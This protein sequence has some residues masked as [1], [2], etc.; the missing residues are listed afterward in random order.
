[1]DLL[2]ARIQRLGFRVLRAKTPADAY[3]A[4]SNARLG[5][6][7]AVLPQDLPVADLR[8]AITRLRE[9]ASE[10]MLSML[11]TGPRPEHS[12]RAELRASGLD[13]AIF[14]PID[15]HSLRFQLNRA[16]AWRHSSKNR[17]TERAPVTWNVRLRAS[18]RAKEGRVYTLSPR[19]LFVSL[20]APWLRGTGVKLELELPDGGRLRCSGRVAMTNVKGNLMKTA[21]PVGMGIQLD[22]VGVDVEARLALAVE[23]RLRRME[24]SR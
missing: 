9:V 18:R 7:A 22:K 2:A 4:L 21:L 12:T 19:G 6:G 14:E 10:P 23:E 8:G 1:M 24:V 20:P 15:A 11:V 5:I 13:Y 3:V 16:T 17:R